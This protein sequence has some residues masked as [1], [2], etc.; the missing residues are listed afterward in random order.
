MTTITSPE[1]T[2]TRASAHV[3]LSRR[4][5]RAARRSPFREVRE[6][7]RQRALIV[8]AT[9]TGVCSVAAVA[10]AVIVLGLGG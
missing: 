7:A 3:A 9:T 10:L 6:Q 5:R 2:A 4:T 1:P 8:I